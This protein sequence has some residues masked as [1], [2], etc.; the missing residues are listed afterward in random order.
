VHVTAALDAPCGAAELFPWVADLAR[1]PQWLTIVDRVQPTDDGA[2][3]VDLRARLG[4][5]A[6]SKRLRMTR[7]QHDPERLVVFERD[8]ADGRRHSPW[9]LQAELAPSSTVAG[10]THLVMHL[11]YGGG[12]WGPVLERVLADEIESGRDRLLALVSGPTR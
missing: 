3:R 8:E 4:P 2:W 6:R 9:V 10:G 11:S 7:T 5:L 12:L 1:Y